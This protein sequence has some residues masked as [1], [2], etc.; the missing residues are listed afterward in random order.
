VETY[1]LVSDYR[2]DD[3]LKESF[4]QLAIHTFNLDF[5]D[6]YKRGYWDEKYIPYS[7]VHHGKVIS[8]ASVY[9]MSVIIEGQTYRAVQISTVM[10]DQAYRHKGLATKLIQR[11]MDQ[12]EN[13][14]DMIFLFANESVLNFYPRFGFTRF[15]E[16]E[17]SVDI[18]KST[19]QMKKD[20][21]LKQ[22]KLEQDLPILE[23]FAD[24]R[25]TG[26]MT[27]D[28]EDHGSLLMFYFTLVWPDAI[29]YIEALDTIVLMNEENET[30]H[31]FDI[32][33]LQT[34][35]V[36][37]VV[38]SIVK[39]TTEKVIFYFTPDTSIDGLH[40]VTTPNDEDALFIYT[41][42]DWALGH[43]MFPIT[44]HC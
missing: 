4:N 41:K 36:E 40:A 24:K 22:L 30:M 3:K 25:Q 29:F 19:I 8:N 43:F 9:L 42:K 39:E 12:Y 31:V 14:C 6:W 20:I 7:F 5:S 34:P 37:E 32:I 18:N 38:A 16:S 2:H 33:S 15:H 35:N 13:D 28:A 21:Q 26:S 23:Q 1:E 44:A 10:T 11:I 17:F 27:L